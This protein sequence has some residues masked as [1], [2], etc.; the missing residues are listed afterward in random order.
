MPPAS[1]LSPPTVP[2]EV[3]AFAEENG[4]SEYVLPVLEAARRAF[5][6]APM[7]V[8]VD[9][10]A[11]LPE[12]RFI[13]IDADV[14]GYDADQIFAADEKWVDGLMRCCPSVHRHFFV[15]GLWGRA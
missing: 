12:V 13:V 8:R 9:E 10:D 6:D 7:E 11:E 4:V 5:P 15:L 14:T 3:L 2:A 1:I